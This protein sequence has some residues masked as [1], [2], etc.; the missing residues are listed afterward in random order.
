MNA[1]AAEKEIVQLVLDNFCRELR[2]L[3][4]GWL[5]RAI[6]GT[7]PAEGYACQLSKLDERGEMTGDVRGVWRVTHNDVISLPASFAVPEPA[8]C[9]GMYYDR[10]TCHFVIAADH[11]GVVMGCQVGPRFGSGVR[12]EVKEDE[13]GHIKLWLAETLWRS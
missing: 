10:A 4:G 7:A 1:D 2:G 9:S 12:Y 11:K 3:R 13:S 8:G 6:M 5:S